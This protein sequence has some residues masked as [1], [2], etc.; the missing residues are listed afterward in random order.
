M[1]KALFL[2]NPS[3][4]NRRQL[5]EVNAAL[6]VVRGAGVDATASATRSA[7]NAAEQVRIALAAGYDTVFACGGDGTVHDVLQALVGSDVVLGVIPVGT[8]NVLAHDLGLPLAPVEAARAC[9]RADIRRIALGRVEF[10]TFAGITGSRYFVAVLGIGADAYLFYKLD[11]QAKRRLGILSY[12]ATATS[13]WLTHRTQSF[14]ATYAPTGAEE[15]DRRDVTQLLAVRIRNFGGVLG[16][17]VPGAG[18]DRNELAL[19]LFRT[20]SRIKYLRYVLQG[21]MRARSPIAGIELAHSKE[22]VCQPL[23]NDSSDIL[24]E[25]D[26]ELLGTLPARVS[27]VPDA[28]RLLVPASAPTSHRPALDPGKN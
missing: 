23:P 15:L 21:L 4:G 22:V 10:Q 9:L 16:E 12:Y 28:L 27:V 20:R 5:S 26:G 1:R 3:S 17:L 14:S 25:A 2:Y 13:L 6:G 18:L 8:A 19:A 7:A 11:P 24:V